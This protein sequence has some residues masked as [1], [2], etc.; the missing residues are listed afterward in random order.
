[1][2][3]EQTFTVSGTWT[4][5]A[6]ILPEDT[7]EFELI[8]GGGSGAHATSGTANG[9]LGGTFLKGRLRYREMGSPA[10]SPV[11]IGGGSGPRSNAGNGSLGGQTIFN[12][13]IAAGGQGG[14]AGTQTANTIDPRMIALATQA[15]APSSMLIAGA[16]GAE[17]PTTN[18]PPRFGGPSGG[19]ASAAN[20]SVTNPFTGAV[21]G[22]GTNTGTA[23]GG[24]GTGPGAGGG[25][26]MNATLSGSYGGGAAGRAIIRVYRGL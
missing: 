17:T 20:N 9:G 3:D 18:Q 23:T 7:V 10:T 2:L 13:F 24:E 22:S 11:T 1:M 14:V 12:G 8:G 5:P 4:P 21:S 25:G 6:G 16:I 15:T 19:S 26:K